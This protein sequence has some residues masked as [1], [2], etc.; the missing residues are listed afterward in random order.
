MLGKGLKALSRYGPRGART[1]PADV[2]PAEGPGPVFGF[3]AEVFADGVHSD[4][5]GFLFE[6]GGVA[7]AV[8]EEVVLPLDRVMGC[9]VVFPTGDGW[10]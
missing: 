4:V 6:F 3:C 9:D 1:L 10:D 7:Q 8:V 5:F 2:I